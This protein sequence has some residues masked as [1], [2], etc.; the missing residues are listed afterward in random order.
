MQAAIH[1][2]AMFL[3]I[4]LFIACSGTANEEKA[5][6]IYQRAQGLEKQ[7]RILEALQEY[8]RLIDYKKTKAF[9]TAKAHLS[10]DGI[11][12]G[13]AIHSWSIKKMFKVKN[14]LIQKGAEKHPDGNVVVPLSIKDGW[15]SYI[16]VEYSTGSKFIFGVISGG[17]DKKLGTEDDLILYHQK[18]AQGTPPPSAASAPSQNKKSSHLAES[19]VELSDLLQEKAR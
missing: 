14:Q 18:D 6:A 1:Q 7:G 12:I 19:S 4:A 10:N 5:R 8:D 2:R 16:R 13:K 17:P 15:G 9:E 11:S 3:L